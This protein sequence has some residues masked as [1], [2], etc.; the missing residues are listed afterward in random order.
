MR[1]Q[2]HI[3][4]LH[5]Q[6]VF[7]YRA[8]NLVWFIE[9]LINPFV[10]MLF[11]R[12]AVGNRATVGGWTIDQIQSYYLIMIFALVFLMHSVEDII[13]K[14]DIKEGNLAHF[15]LKPYSF[16]LLRLHSEAPWRLV[17]GFYGLIA[18][19]TLPPLMQFSIKISSDPFMMF[20]AILA[21]VLAY[22]ISFF[23]KTIIAF[24]AFWM[25]DIHAIV[26]IQEIFALLFT[27][28][29]M[30]L[31]FMPSSIQTIAHFTPLPYIIYYPVTILL[32]MHDVDMIIKII[33]SQLLWIVGLVLVYKFMWSRGLRTF[34]GVG[35]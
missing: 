8:R 20:A 5:F 24:L 9:S 11:W 16:L 33:G 17:Q 12:G 13:A 21:S 31:T 30:P 19:I 4:L 28:V 15:L 27:G 1:K 18:I 23:Y 6:H 14:K 26:E 7:Q 22:F 3:F 25:T 32:G 29:I 10:L 34:T 2:L 35:Q